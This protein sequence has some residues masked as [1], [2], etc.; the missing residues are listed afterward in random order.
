MSKRILIT[1]AASGFGRGAALELARRGHTV[2]AGVQVA[3]QATE[4][5]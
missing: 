5:L 4:P 2:I 1:G 3:P